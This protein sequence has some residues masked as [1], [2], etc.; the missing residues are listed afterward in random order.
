[1]EAEKEDMMRAGDCNKEAEESVSMGDTITSRSATGWEG[2]SGDVGEGTAAAWW[3]EAEEEEAADLAMRTSSRSSC[4]MLVLVLRA[5]W[6][7]V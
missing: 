3:S 4:S 2:E 1:M 5:S 6:T 7:S